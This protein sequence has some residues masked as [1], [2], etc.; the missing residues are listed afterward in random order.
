MAEGKNL[1]S[2][3]KI[4]VQ[5]E[6]DLSP[7]EEKKL[8]D[9]IKEKYSHEFVFITN[10]PKEVRPFYHM[11]LE[12]NQDLTKSF[13]LLWNGL[14]ITT[15][16]QREHRYEMLKKQAKEKKLSSKSIQYYLDFFK[17]G[18]PPHGG[19]GFGPSRFLMKI[20]GVSNVREV[21]YLYRGVKRLTP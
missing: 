7:E 5:R 2:E 15:G 16:A 17:Y 9:L 19:F 8:S 20:L 13:D 1:I 10:Y 6:A 18:C 12:N 14:E 4:I 11:R 21:T 3:M